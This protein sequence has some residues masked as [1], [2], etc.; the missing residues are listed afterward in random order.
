MISLDLEKYWGVRDHITIK[1]Y[2]ENLE[3]V[4]KACDRIHKLFQKY[5]IEATWATVGFLMFENKKELLN[6]IPNT[7]PEY[8][9]ISLN[10]YENLRK[11]NLDPKY[12]FSPAFINE[13]L[14]DSSQ[15]FASHTFSHYYC[16]EPGQNLESFEDDLKMFNESTKNKL[17]KINLP[18]SIVFPRNQINKKYLVLL[19]KYGIKTYRG[20][21]R[22]WLYKKKMNIT[23]KRAIRLLDSYLNLTGPNTYKKEE[24]SI[25][26]NL[27]NIP[28]SRFLRPYSKLM[29][30]L[31]F[32]KFGRIK[33]QMTYA[34]KNN[35]LFH[36]WWH[37]HNFG[38]DL[39]ANLKFLEKILQH[40]SFLN[41]K[42]NY[43][44]LNM[45]NYYE[46]YGREK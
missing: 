12:H 34:A 9:E 27:M 3:M 29:S 43:H 30:V 37:P 31:D 44:S 14:M 36:L 40:Y 17:D 33:K 21:E 4:D 45:K 6:Y 35:E 7:L 16:N 32:A 24:V 28:S 19:N 39:E 46:K 42:F 38:K 25:K 23:F 20:N 26:N 5:K 1:E 22:T 13:I 18:K 8:N 11:E 10:P 41:H 15:E 2:R